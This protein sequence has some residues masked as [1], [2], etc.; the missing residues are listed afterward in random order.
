MNAAVLFSHT[1]IHIHLSKHTF[2][3]HSFF[4]QKSAVLRNEF[5]AARTLVIRQI[6]LLEFRWTYGTLHFK[7][8][9]FEFL[10]QRERLRLMSTCLI[11]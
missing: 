11:S 1:H 3:I 2:V 9:S 5:D 6:S 10:E 4:V 8:F 7:H